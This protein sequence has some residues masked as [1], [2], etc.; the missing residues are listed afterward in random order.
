MFFVFFSSNKKEENN[1]N[2]YSVLSRQCDSENTKKLKKERSF[3]SGIPTQ[4]NKKRGQLN[5]CVV[6]AKNIYRN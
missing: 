5:S 3:V 6:K 2:N 1:E 4:K